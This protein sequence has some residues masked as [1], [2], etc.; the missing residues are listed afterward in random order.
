MPMSQTIMMGP[1][2][3]ARGR[4]MPKVLPLIEIVTV[5][6]R[7]PGE[8]ASV[9]LSLNHQVGSRRDP[10]RIHTRAPKVSWPRPGDHREE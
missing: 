8:M 7:Y 2:S 9:I 5:V 3:Q 1:R 6:T 4:H 10:E